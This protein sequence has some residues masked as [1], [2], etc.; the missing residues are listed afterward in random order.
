MSI[1]SSCHRARRLDRAITHCSPQ[2]PIRRISLSHQPLLPI[3][4]HSFLLFRMTARPHLAAYRASHARPRALLVQLAVLKA[5]C[6]TSEKSL[7][8]RLLRSSPAY[9][10]LQLMLLLPASTARPLRCQ[11][12]AQSRPFVPYSCVQSSLT[13]RLCEYI[14]LECSK[15]SVL[16]TSTSGEQCG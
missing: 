16:L 3:H 4:L 1:A 5:G 8:W 6:N 10:L 11:Q 2:K 12:R 15:A 13:F 14:V 7:L 9:Q